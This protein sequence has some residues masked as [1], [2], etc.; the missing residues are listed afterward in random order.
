MA[1]KQFL[2]KHGTT[3]MVGVGG[4]LVGTIVSEV[5]I[6]SAAV[7]DTGGTIHGCRNNLLGLLRVVDSASQSCNSGETSLNWDQNGVKGYARINGTSLDTAHSRN[8]TNVTTNSIEGDDESFSTYTCLTISGTP[9]TILST[10]YEY[11]DSAFKDGSG[12]WISPSG[13]G[14]PTGFSANCPSTANVALVTH[15][16]QSPA[17]PYYGTVVIY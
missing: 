16:Y 1:I 9:G 4:V 2:R 5:A 10:P 6:A 11:S 8:I 12:T 7:P 13:G 17:S 3:F 15:Q 14:T